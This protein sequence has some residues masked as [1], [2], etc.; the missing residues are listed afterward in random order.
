MENSMEVPQKM[1]SGPQRCIYTRM[2]TAV[3]FTIAKMQ[4]QPKCTSMDKWIK[5]MCFIH[6]TEYQSALKKKETVTHT[7]TWINL[8]DIMLSHKRINIA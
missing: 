7:T 2:F 6:T 1:K 3:L 8:E 5:K 4:K